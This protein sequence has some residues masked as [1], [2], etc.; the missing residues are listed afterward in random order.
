MIFIDVSQY[1]KG[2][3][4]ADDRAFKNLNS[5]IATDRAIQQNDEFFLGAPGREQ[6]ISLESQRQLGVADAVGSNLNSIIAADA[7]SIL[8]AAATRSV[9]GL[10]ASAEAQFTLPAIPVLAQSVVDTRVANQ[11]NAQNQAEVITPNAQL[12]Q[13][14][15]QQNTLTNQPL[16]QQIERTRL[17]GTERRLGSQE[18]QLDY[19]QQRGTMQ[20]ATD[21]Q[22]EGQAGYI[23]K[24]IQDIQQSANANKILTQPQQ[25]RL[26]QLQTQYQTLQA[27]INIRT[28]PKVEQSNNLTR[29]YNDSVTRG[30][31]QRLPQENDLKASQ[32]FLQQMLTDV[33][34]GDVPSLD[35]LSDAERA[36]KQLEVSAKTADQPQQAEY[37]TARLALNNLITKMKSGNVIYD[38]EYRDAV[39]AYNMLVTASNTAQQ[40][41]KAALVEST[42]TLQQGRAEQ[43]ISNLADDATIADLTRKLRIGEL[44]FNRLNAPQQQRMVANELKIKE[45]NIGLA[46]ELLP[47]TQLAKTL[48]QGMALDDVQQL[49]QNKQYAYEVQDIKAQQAPAAARA[50]QFAQSLNNGGKIIQQL[51][52]KRPISLTQNDLATAAKNLQNNGLLNPGQSLMADSTG[53]Y[54]QSTGAAP[55]PLDNLY[56]GI[57]ATLAKPTAP[58][59]TTYKTTTY[60]QDG[61]AYPVNTV[62]STG[63]PPT[64]AD[65]QFAGGGA[66]TPDP[67]AKLPPSLSGIIGTA[68]AKATLDAAARAARGY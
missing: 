60:I 50:N 2:A 43:G 66:Q 34:I 62:T 63:A 32:T 29:N 56:R 15:N 13:A 48:Q 14:N 52:V 49:K 45:S 28:A 51:N 39:R 5:L 55:I 54:I 44:Q 38:D 3:E 64:A 4:R 1:S 10:Q 59:P 58:K 36:L 65:R 41:A 61:V 40:P 19:Q 25:Q 17:E 30:R 68:E 16:T 26:Q 67:N 12:I 53:I 18:Q 24:Q 57:L 47:V 11:F 42:T 27:E 35:R 22:L 9:A 7:N 6:A 37:D 33:K 21:L 8:G 20:A 23:R 31:A 46:L